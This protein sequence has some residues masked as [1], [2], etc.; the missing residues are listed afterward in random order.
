MATEHILEPLP[1][2]F[3]MLGKKTFISKVEFDFDENGK[4]IAAFF[5]SEQIILEDGIQISRKVHR[6]VVS[7]DQAKEFIQKY[8]TGK[9]YEI[10]IPC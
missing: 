6:D 4:F 7:M 1:I 8:N 3:D 5:E 10:N 2:L 9:T